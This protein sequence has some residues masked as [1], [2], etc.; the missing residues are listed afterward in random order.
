MAGIRKWRLG[1]HGATSG[2]WQCHLFPR[3]QRLNNLGVLGRRLNNSF[4]SG[5]PHNYYDAGQCLCPIVLARR[6]GPPHGVFS[7][8]FCPRTC[9]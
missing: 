7:R 3:M 4:L 8:D 9:R 5:L 6:H 1:G 2:Y